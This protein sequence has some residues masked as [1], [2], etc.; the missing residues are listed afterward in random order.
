MCKQVHGRT[1]FFLTDAPDQFPPVLPDPPAVLRIFVGYLLGG[2]E[3]RSL[4][5]VYPFGSTNA[6]QLSLDRPGQVHCRWPCR[7]QLGRGGCQTLVEQGW[8]RRCQSR[9]V[10]SIARR[11]PDQPRTADMHLSDCLRHR[12]DGTHLFNYKTVWKKALVD[13]PNETLVR[14]VR[15][16]RSIMLTP[17]FH[18]SLECDQDSC[19]ARSENQGC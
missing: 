7:L 1:A 11:R 15:P 8:P 18:Q 13:Q 17:Y 16:N 5:L 2:V 19:K 6:L 3:R 4:F 14:F 9:Q 10:H 12:L